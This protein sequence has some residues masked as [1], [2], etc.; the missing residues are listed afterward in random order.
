MIFDRL[1]GPLLRELDDA[2]AEARRWEIFWISYHCFFV[3]WSGYFA[4]FQACLS[5]LPL[6]ARWAI[7]GFHA[8]AFWLFLFWLV[9]AYRSRLRR[10]RSS[11]E[12]RAR[13]KD[14][15]WRGD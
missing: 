4:Y 2:D 12:L 15:E 7:G 6:V 1:R 5:T 13:L 3:G 8:I 14:K 9:S 10:L 11:R